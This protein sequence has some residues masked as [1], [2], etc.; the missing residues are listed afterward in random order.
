[1]NGKGRDDLPSEILFKAE[2]V[3]VTV[4]ENQSKGMRNLALKIKNSLNAIL[5]MIIDVK[6]MKNNILMN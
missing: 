2:K 4:S 1:M 6:N 3:L 5:T